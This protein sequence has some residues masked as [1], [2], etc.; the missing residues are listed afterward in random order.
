MSSLEKTIDLLLEKGTSLTK[1][2][3]DQVVYQLSYQRELQKVY[4]NTVSN[5]VDEL[6]KLKIDN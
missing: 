2:E 3:V 5:L 6:T 4:T 1:E